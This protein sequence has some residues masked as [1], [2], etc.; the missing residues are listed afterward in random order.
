VGENGLDTEAQT[1][2]GPYLNLTQTR[3]QRQGK[4]HTYSASY[5]SGD[6]WTHLDLGPGAESESTPRNLWCAN[7][8]LGRHALGI[9]GKYCIKGHAHKYLAYL[10]Q[11]NWLGSE[12]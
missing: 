2:Y 3:M 7:L 12:V 5:L 6:T 9:K 8:L 4:G 11:W 1:S 10:R